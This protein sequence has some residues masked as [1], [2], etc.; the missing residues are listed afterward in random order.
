MIWSLIFGDIRRG[1]GIA[2]KDGLYPTQNAEE[3]GKSMGTDRFKF[4]GTTMIFFTMQRR[5]YI[6]ELFAERKWK[7][8][9]LRLQVIRGIS[10]CQQILE[11][12]IKI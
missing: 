3:A 8:N 1:L 2:M 11:V 9:L 6:S 12:P 7:Q 5:V 10:T 4:W